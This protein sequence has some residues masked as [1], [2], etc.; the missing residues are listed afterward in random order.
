MP[1]L[2]RGIIYRT[3]D[4]VREEVV[5]FSVEKILDKDYKHRFEKRR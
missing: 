3:I 5:S 2:D 1:F 4:G